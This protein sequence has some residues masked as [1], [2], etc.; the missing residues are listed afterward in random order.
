[1][2]LGSKFI[3]GTRLQRH[4]EEDKDGKPLTRTKQQFKDECNINVIMDRF[5][6]T[7]QLPTMI[8]QNPQFADFSDMPTYKEALELVLYSNDQFMALPANVRERFRNDPANFLEFASNPENAEE[9]AKL[10]LMKPE[11]VERVKSEKAA[12][13]APPA[14]PKGNVPP[15]ENK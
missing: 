6:K 10:G 12:K 13:E 7:G 5:K 1:M 14:P 8:K 9:M 11:A 3:T 15:A 2:S 4:F